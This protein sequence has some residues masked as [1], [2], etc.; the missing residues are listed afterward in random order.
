MMIGQVRRHFLWAVTLK[1]MCT[2]RV[3]GVAIHRHEGM[4]VEYGACVN[5]LPKSYL[6]P[7]CKPYV[8][9]GSQ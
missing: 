7:G 9:D 1:G 4:K 5:Q 2:R 3:D 8:R 6:V